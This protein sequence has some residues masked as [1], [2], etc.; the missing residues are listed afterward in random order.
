[1]L[2]ESSMITEDASVQGNDTQAKAKQAFAV[3]QLALKYSR[4]EV[5][6]PS[7]SLFQGQTRPEWNP[8]ID[9]EIQTKS[10]PLA[11]N[12]HEVT[13]SINLSG[14]T[15]QGQ[16]IFQIKLEQAGV[17]HIEGFDDAEKETLLKG[18][19]PNQLYPYIAARVNEL[20]IHAGY[21]PV[22]MAPVDFLA[23]YQQN[24]QQPSP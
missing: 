1:M 24:K 22:Q 16:S 11:D 7:Y 18:Y 20:L 17:F 12:K 15:Q 10:N 4:L 21:P 9:T 8:K 23:L 5:S 19:A 14:K 6:L 13:L 2:K 3:M